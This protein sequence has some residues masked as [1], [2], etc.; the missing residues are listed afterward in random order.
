MR[1]IIISCWLFFF[2]CLFF[3][4][5]YCEETAAKEFELQ[6]IVVDK[7]V[8]DGYS[9]VLISLEKS[10]SYKI[11]ENSDGFKGEMLESD[12]WI[13]P[14]TSIDGL[15]SEFPPDFKH[16]GGDVKV[17][18]YNGEFEALRNTP[19]KI[20]WDSQL[21]SK[22]DLVFL[23]KSTSGFIYKAKIV[24][25]QRESVTIVYQRLK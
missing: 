22:P 4:Q 8:F 14:T 9:A 13:K 20:E 16:K 25:P 2:I 21:I 15:S 11:P 3:Q 12:L 10:K 23:V 5:G 17:A 19:S 18:K 7:D 1:N 24:N 6:K